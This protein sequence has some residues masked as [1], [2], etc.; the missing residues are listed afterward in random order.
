[1]W[2]CPDCCR[3]FKRINQNH[4]CGDISTVDE[5]ILAQ[6]EEVQPLL[7]SIRETI[8]NAIPDAIEKISWRMPT[9]W[10]KE[11]II[12][13]ASFKNHIG[14]FPGDMTNVPFL[15]RLKDYKT[16]KGTIHLPLNKPIDHDLIHDIVM[17]RVETNNG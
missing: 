7:R 2:K 17:W 8:K 9:Y 6:R 15:D 3:E 13:F 4:T 11:N 16:S 1:M 10:K 14:I 5:Y 12:H